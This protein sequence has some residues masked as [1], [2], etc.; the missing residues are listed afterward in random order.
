MGPLNTFEYS[1]DVCS[2]EGYRNEIW[3]NNSRLS[4]Y[5]SDDFD[6]SRL[7]SAFSEMGLTEESDEGRLSRALQSWMP[8]YVINSIEP[9]EKPPYEPVF[10]GKLGRDRDKIARVSFDNT[11]RVP[12]AVRRSKSEKRTR[13][14]NAQQGNKLKR[15]KTNTFKLKRSFTEIRKNDK[16]ISR[17]DF[18]NGRLVRTSS[19]ESISTHYSS[20]FELS[21]LEAKSDISSGSHKSRK[22]GKQRKE[23]KDQKSP[24]PVAS[25]WV[26]L[27]SKKSLGAFDKFMRGQNVLQ[28]ETFATYS[29]EFES[30][31][32]EMM[33][34]DERRMVFNS[35]KRTGI[36]LNKEL[37]KSGS[38]TNINEQVHLP[39]KR[40]KMRTLSAGHKPLS[41]GINLEEIKQRIEKERMAAARLKQ[42]SRSS[43]RRRSRVASSSARSEVSSNVSGIHTPSIRSLSPSTI[44][45]SKQETVW[46]GD[47]EILEMD[48]RRGLTTRV[49]KRIKTTTSA[50]ER[51]TGYGENNKFQ[52]RVGR[53]RDFPQ[54]IDDDY[55]FKPKIVQ[56]M[57]ISP[58]LSSVIRQD[59]QV[60]MGRPRYHEI[61]VKDLEWWNRGQKLNRAHRNLKV[62][63]WLHS[64]KE[65]EFEHLLDV[66]ILDTPPESRDD[67]VE[68]HVEAADEPDLKPLYMT[69]FK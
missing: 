43:R 66:E 44:P 45:D 8:D 30:E 3:Q 4:W 59:I 20:L 31:A 32:F 34:P 26:E 22:R 18:D 56:R 27:A 54:L 55:G 51:V 10:T 14:S 1:M 68:M 42:E 38:I 61:S 5:G 52:R 28:I 58:F 11:K 19:D 16:P 57:R 25:R 13:L 69:D 60:R 63:N 17:K 2:E 50:L 15:A 40:K 64:L 21:S 12:S 47:K 35:A 37:K 49:K 48:L 9:M 41:K 6:E 29:G 62:F 23:V 53:C 39:K 65:D 24:Q 46:K 33:D 67:I 7:P 36:R